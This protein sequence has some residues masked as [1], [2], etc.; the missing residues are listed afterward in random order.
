MIDLPDPYNGLAQARW[1]EGTSVTRNKVNAAVA[2]SKTD[3]PIVDVPSYDEPPCAPRMQR[4][5]R[6]GQERNPPLPDY[7]YLFELQ[8][9]QAAQ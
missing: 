1:A 7:V 5:V 9:H 6:G 3:T 2:R 4:V 8:P